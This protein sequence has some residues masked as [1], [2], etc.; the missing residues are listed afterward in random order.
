MRNPHLEAMKEAL[1][2]WEGTASVLDVGSLDINGSFRSAIE[3]RE[4][5]YTGLDIV[6][7]E[8]VDVVSDDLY[9]YP[10][11]DDSF[12]IVIS[13]STMEHVESIW[14]WVPELARL[15]K[16]GGLLIIITHHTFAYH[17]HP[18][19]CWRI[20]PDGMRHLFDHTG[21]LVDYFV[22]MFNKKDIIGMAWKRNPGQRENP[23]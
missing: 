7:G 17:A 18:V 22:E 5:E 9:S 2:R 4:W 11:D 13:G 6:V 21:V 1:S 12:D 8:N 14:L 19:D 15:V 10:F 23:K 16:P 20:M 3:S